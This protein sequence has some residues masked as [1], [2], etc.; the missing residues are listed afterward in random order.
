MKSQK[1]SVVQVSKKSQRRHAVDAKLA[2]KQMEDVVVPRLQLT[3]IDR[4]VYSHL[5][6]HT[7]LEG[8]LRL[9][10]SMVW[11]ARG[12]RLCTGTVREAVRRLAGRGA[13]RVVQR[14]KMGHVVEVR[15][16]AEIRAAR[17][18][19]KQSQRYAAMGGFDRIGTG[20]QFH[21]STGWGRSANLEEIDFMQTKELRQAIYAREGGRCFYCL[22]QLT[23][24]VSGVDH[25][26]P[27]A[28]SGRN[29]Y[30]NLVASCM[31]CNSQK[32]E[33]AAGDFLRRLY[34]K[35]R[36]TSAELEDRLCALDALAAGKLR[37][38]ID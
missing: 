31:E 37:P 16:P 13:L 28:Q 23:S 3:V 10:F 36:L 2:W 11:L 9:R 15:L 8:K 19:H 7:R 12:T 21:S 6:R 14:G 17:L 27:R 1:N 24:A 29:T 30:R 4:S 34:R 35:R 20:E 38:R 26:V 33:R 18:G 5:L 25:V 22:R 32:G